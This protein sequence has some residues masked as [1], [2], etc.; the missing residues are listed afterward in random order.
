MSASPRSA[1]WPGAIGRPACPFTVSTTGIVV[2][3]ETLSRIR[4]GGVTTRTP[5]GAPASAGGQ[6]GAAREARRRRP[7]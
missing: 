1:P 5:I 6:V 4:S 7:P 2:P 3:L